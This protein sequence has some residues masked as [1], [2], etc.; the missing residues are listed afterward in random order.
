MKYEVIKPIREFF[1]KEA[2]RYGIFGVSV[3]A[4]TA[5]AIFMTPLR[6]TSFFP[7]SITD[8]S[9]GEIYQQMQDDPDS[10]L[11]LDVRSVQAFEADHA[12]GAKSA[13]L[14]TLYFLK[15]TLPRKGQRIALICSG[16]VASGVGFSY[17]EHYGFTNVVRVEGGIEA[18]KSAG[19]PTAAGTDPY[20]E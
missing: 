8:V 18:W 11:L 1:D 3:A 15:N 6:Y 17:L 10:V 2:I 9:A 12:L 7:P 16:G 5:A 13:P 20:L 14:H 4:I 19:L